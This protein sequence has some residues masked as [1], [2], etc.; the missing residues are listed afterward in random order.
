VYTYDANDCTDFSL[1]FTTQFG[2]EAALKYGH[3]QPLIMDSTVG[4][5]NLKFPLTILIVVDD[6]N[7]GIPVAWLMSSS[8]SIESISRF[9]TDFRF[10]V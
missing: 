2:I 8:E 7:N 1:A 4:T 5:N 9:L 3:E 6:H 10:R